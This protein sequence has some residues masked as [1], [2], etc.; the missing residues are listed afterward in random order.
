MKIADVEITD[1]FI[2][3][4]IPKDCSNCPV[5]LALSRA[6]GFLC[7]VNGSAWRFKNYDEDI[8]YVLP[9]DVSRWI[10]NFDA[11]SLSWPITFQIA[12]KEPIR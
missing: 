2:L 1:E 12:Y 3:N 5:A 11:H 9:S 10:G 6:T 4:G 7:V 8:Y